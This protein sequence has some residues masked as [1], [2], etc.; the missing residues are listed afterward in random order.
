MNLLFFHAL[1]LP[2][3][4]PTAFHFQCCDVFLYILEL[5]CMVASLLIAFLYTWVSVGVSA[6]MNALGGQN[7]PSFNQLNSGASN[8]S[9]MVDSKCAFVVP[10]S[11]L[12]P[13]S[14]V[15]VQF[16]CICCEHCR[17]VWKYCLMM[18]N[19]SSHV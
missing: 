6:A 13:L 12:H 1:F 8:T 16:C 14:H 7:M 19:G 10:L 5:L 11:Q 17:L 9:G 4:P 18:L 2:P 3:P 15:C